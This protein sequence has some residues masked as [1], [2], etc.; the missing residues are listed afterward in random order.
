MLKTYRKI[1]TIQAE[2]FDGSAEMM[3]KY[4]LLY[5]AEPEGILLPTKEGKMLMYE[6]D[7]IATGVNGEHW[8]IADNIFKKTYV[9]V[10]DSENTY[11]R[12]E[13]IVKTEY[14]VMINDKVYLDGF[15]NGNY[16]FTKDIEQ[17]YKFDILY[18]ERRLLKPS[19]IGALSE[20]KRLDGK[21]YK[22]E[23]VISEV[24]E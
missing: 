13:K 19:K 5:D 1:T 3:K 14:V 7:W 21:V 16:T 8:A 11:V 23:T 15:L 17:S 9:E 6:G 24:E 22:L 20:A 12:R 4:D 10:K 18:D 2:Q